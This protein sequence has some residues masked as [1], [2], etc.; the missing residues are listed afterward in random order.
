MLWGRSVTHVPG[1]TKRR[2]SR[3]S[4][5]IRRAVF[6]SHPQR[7]RSLSA[8]PVPFLLRLRRPNVLPQT[9][10]RRER[11]RNAV[12]KAPGEDMRLDGLA[13]MQRPVGSRAIRR[14]R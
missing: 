12:R 4:A 2:P 7:R 14:F 11:L 9:G 8:T 1:H 10:S 13:V 3:A 6:R 5:G